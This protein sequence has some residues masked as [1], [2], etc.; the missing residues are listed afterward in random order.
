MRRRSHH[1]R[2]ARDHS[3]EHLLAN[4]S[5][6]APEAMSSVVR[7][8]SALVKGRA[9]Q[10]GT[11]LCFQRLRARTRV[12]VNTA[13]TPGAFCASVMSMRWW[14]GVLSSDVVRN[15]GVQD[16]GQVAAAE[17]E[18]PVDR[19]LVGSPTSSEAIHGGPDS[20]GSLV[21]DLSGR[22]ADRLTMIVR[23]NHYE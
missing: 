11:S 8:T 1:V 15:T 17:E 18:H 14:A 23:Q 4:P 19:E 13:S 3:G 5:L 12:S 21:I 6:S 16:R 20:P 22:R 2:L 10:S 9:K 7:A